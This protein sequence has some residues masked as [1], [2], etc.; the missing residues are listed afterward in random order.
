M[1]ALLNQLKQH[2]L[3]AGLSQQALAG[4]AG[5]SRQAYSAL[6]SGGANPSTE[7]ALRLARSLK[8]NVDHLFSLPEAAP[9][10]MPAELVGPSIAKDSASID[11]PATR[12]QLVQVGDRLL[13]GRYLGLGV[14]VNP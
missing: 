7:V 5:I 10:A 11:K 8:T 4:L 3:E 9:Q 6:E 2:R 1:A 12:V 14:L 13:E